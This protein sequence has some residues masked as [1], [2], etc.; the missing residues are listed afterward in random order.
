MHLFYT[1]DILASPDL[2]EEEAGHCLRVLRL[3]TGDEVT[4]TDGKGCFYRAVISAATGKRCQV[5]V[6]E[7]MPQEPFWKGHL[8]LAISDQEY[9]PG[10]VVCRE[11]YGNRLR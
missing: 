8:H 3:G 10:G 2:P 5:K 6:L 1:P 11:G 4:L 7:K 9:G